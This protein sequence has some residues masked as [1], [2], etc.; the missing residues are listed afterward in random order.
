MRR[1]S[2]IEAV[3]EA[4]LHGYW[5]GTGEPDG[6]IDAVEFIQSQRRDVVHSMPRMMAMFLFRYRLKWSLNQIGTATCRN[7][8]TVLHGIRVS[9]DEMSIDKTLRRAIRMANEL[10][11]EREEIME[12]ELMAND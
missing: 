2:V 4:A 9:E 3:C 5:R 7:H 1:N 12:S 8:A 6:P 11:D 10:L